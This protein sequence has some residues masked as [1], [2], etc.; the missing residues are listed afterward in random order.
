MR[1]DEMESMLDKLGVEYVGVRGN[2]IQG[3]CPAHLERTG[4][5]DRNPSWFINADTGA[6]IC[7]SCQFRGS[8]YSLVAALKNFYNV[9]GSYN[10]DDVKTWVQD[11]GGLIQ[12]FEKAVTKSDKIFEELVYISESSLA[13]F[14]EPPDYALKS[15]GLT[16][17]A[18]NKYQ[19]LW[20][21]VYNNWV[22]P[23]RDPKTHELLGW[24]EKGYSGRFFKNYPA[25]M[26]KSLALFGYDKYA[27]GDMIVVESP[28]DVVRLESIGI[29]GGVATFGSMISDTQLFLIRNADRIVFAMDSD[30]AGETSSMKLLEMTKRLKFESWFFNYAHTDMKDVGGMSK[31]EVTAGIDTAIHSV[32]YGIKETV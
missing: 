32:R 19:I 23:I 6:H 13:A 7:F 27:G 24:Q 26:K 16:N 10:Y 3:Y 28:L 29:S 8:L 4:K 22:I 9:D 5:Q 31:V 18:A 14:V 11:G 2:E 17:A 1:I 12:A 15:R 21:K 20:N 30:Q 25:G